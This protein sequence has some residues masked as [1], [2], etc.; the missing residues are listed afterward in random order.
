MSEFGLTRVPST[1]PDT[2]VW[3]SSKPFFRRSAAAFMRSSE[4]VSLTSDP[5]LGFLCEI[6]EKHNR[7]IYQIKYQSIKINLN[8]AKKSPTNH[9]NYQNKTN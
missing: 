9:F 7:I 8:H 5:A 3:L 2:V 4:P 1:R 6:K